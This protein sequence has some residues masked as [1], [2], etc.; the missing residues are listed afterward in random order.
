MD[1]N[2]WKKG[3]RESLGQKDGEEGKMFESCK[4]VVLQLSYNC[5][6]TVRL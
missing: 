4:T 3:L 2:F 6:V 5:L 1:R